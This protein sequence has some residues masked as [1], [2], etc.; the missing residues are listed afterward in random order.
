M[1]DYS[2]AHRPEVVQ[3]TSRMLR[4]DEDAYRDFYQLY[5]RRLFRYLVVVASG[6]EEAAKDAL[7]QTMLRVV[8]H[9][10]CFDSEETFWS[11]LT[12]L[13]RSAA[14]DQRRKGLNYRMLLGRFFEQQHS[15]RGCTE[16]ESETRLNEHLTSSL[17]ALPEED[18]EIVDLK[19]LER[20]PVKNIAAQLNTTEKAIESRLVRIRQRLKTNILDQLTNAD[21]T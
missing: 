16:R 9:I 17:A 5:G 14:V 11:W 10:R 4:G 19:Y 20:M 6:Q 15:D 8:R 12:V 3:L 13:A 7:Q 2:S 18:R 21:T 1:A